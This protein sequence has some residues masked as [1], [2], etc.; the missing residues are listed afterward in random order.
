MPR[1]L[2]RTARQPGRRDRRIFAA[3]VVLAVPALVWAGLRLAD[4]SRSPAGLPAGD[5]GV[6]HVHGLGVNPA[7]GSLYVATHHGTFRLA[8]STDV[9]RVGG[10]YQDTM[11][12]T[13]AGPN[14]F[15]GSGHPDV[16]GLRRGQ[17]TRLGL[18]ESSDAGVTWRDVSLGGEVDFHGLAFAHDRVYGWDSGSGRFMVSADRRTWDTRSAL[19]LASF[20][21]DPDDAEHIVGAGPDGLVASRDGGRTWSPTQG[22][23]LAV[24]SWD[25]T[26]GLAGA[27]PA[28]DVHRSRDRGTTWT[29]A[30]R[31]PGPPQALLATAT[32]WYA[33][34][35]AHGAT[36]I[37]RSVNKGGTWSLYYR[38]R[39]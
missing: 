25:R 17:P 12:F 13:V 19:P 10:S 37:Y 18:I 5:P 14:Q 4:R 29:A 3:A 34:A 31:L 1:S 36:G 38:D 39:P 11:G 9:R 27:T 22:P 21:V 16:Q 2:Q 6:A 28:G 15:L 23:T 24:L 8:S 35:D 30:G 20:A 26:V 33:A 7:D 32:T